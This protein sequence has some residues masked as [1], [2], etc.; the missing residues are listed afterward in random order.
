MNGSCEC[1][2]P[3][4]LDIFIVDSSELICACSSN[5][6]P[7]AYYEYKGTCN[8]C[9]NGCLCTDEGCHYCDFSQTYR[10]DWYSSRL[11]CPC[12]ESF[13]EYQGKCYCVEPYY[14]NDASKCV[15]M[16]AI[17]NIRYYRNPNETNACYAC[18]A[19]CTCG[20]MGC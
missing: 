8:I 20:S 4:V 18:P 12:E 3:W 15:C 6:Q 16:D 14:L 10:L 2:Y 9:P 19:G 7:S 1:V 17:D 5:L 13:I 11:N